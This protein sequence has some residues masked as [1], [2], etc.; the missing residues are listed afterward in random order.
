MLT[1][2]TVKVIGGRVGGG[3]VVAGT[4]NVSIPADILFSSD[5][6]QLHFSSTIL[7]ERKKTATLAVLLFQPSN[8]A[9]RSLTYHHAAAYK[10]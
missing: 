6:M 2:E 3:R 9:H 10:C 4:F 8:V 7:D 1:D 5:L